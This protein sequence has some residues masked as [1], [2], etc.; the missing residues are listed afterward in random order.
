ME[1]VVD[2]PPNFDQ[3]NK[4][5][6]SLKYRAILYAYGDTIYNPM[7]GVIP[8]ELIAHEEVH[9]ARQDD[10]DHWWDCYLTQP[11]F[12]LAEELAA[13]RAEYQYLMEHAANR[14]LR[15]RALKYVAQRLAAPLYGKI[16]TAAN[17]KKELIR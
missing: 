6:G 15:R 4:T 2:Y 5:F 14:N 10:P 7:D 3:I 12:R 13:H 1:I 17:A 16:I 9:G 11:H 8:P